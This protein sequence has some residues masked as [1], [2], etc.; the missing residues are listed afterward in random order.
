[1]QVEICSRSNNKGNTFQV[2]SCSSSNIKGNKLQVESCSSS[3][4]NKGDK[5]GNIKCLWDL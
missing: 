4:N 2:E 5:P 1:M 3:S